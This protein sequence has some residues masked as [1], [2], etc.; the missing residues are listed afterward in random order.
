MDIKYIVDDSGNPTAVVIPIE[1][2][3]SLLDKIY[4]TEPERNDTEYLL[5]SPAMKKRLL[6]ARSRKGG[7]TWEEVRD[8]LGI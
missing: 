1:E 4:E 6:E 7:M 5:T 8:A 2:W 3:N